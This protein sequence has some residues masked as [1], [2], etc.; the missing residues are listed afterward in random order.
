MP[1][2]FRLPLALAVVLMG[3]GCGWAQGCNGGFG[4]SY[5]AYPQSA[6]VPGGYPGAYS[7]PLGQVPFAPALQQPPYYPGVLGLRRGGYPG[8]VYFDL[9]THLGRAPLSAPSAGYGYEYFPQR[10][11]GY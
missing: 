11:G 5:Y 7:G 6:F 3:A 9:R 10:Y 4:G 8:G 2:L 1:T